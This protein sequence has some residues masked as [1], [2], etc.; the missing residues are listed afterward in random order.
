MLL[1]ALTGTSDHGVNKSLYRRDLDGNEFEVMS[2][3]GGACGA[4]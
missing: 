4:S 1:T 2:S 3:C